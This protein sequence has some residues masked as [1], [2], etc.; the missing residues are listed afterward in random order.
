MS[1]F[2]QFETII[3]TLAE[4]GVCTLTLNR[5]QVHNAFDE[6]MIGELINSLEL[7]EKHQSVRILLVRGS[8]KSFSAGADLKWMQRMA[9]Y[10]E[11]QNFEDARRLATM[12]DRLYRFPETY[13]C[14]C[15]WRRV[16][17][18]SWLGGML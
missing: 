17:R 14:D 4:T 9:E 16:R 12:M 13:S 6:L 2:D 1:E 18:C 15:S 5:P 8:G 7:L 3:V 11:E 10:S